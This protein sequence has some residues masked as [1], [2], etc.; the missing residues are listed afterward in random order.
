MSQDYYCH[1][2]HKSLE[3][4]KCDGQMQD[5]VATAQERIAELEAEN[6]KLHNRIGSLTLDN[7]LLRRSAADDVLTIHT[8][9]EIIDRIKKE[10]GDFRAKNSDLE[11]EN[12]KLRAE[13]DMNEYKIRNMALIISGSRDQ[14]SKLLALVERAADHIG[15]SCMMCDEVRREC[16][17]ALK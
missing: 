5:D 16:K 15:C 14:N 6:A 7:D 13:C 4:C 2:C 3:C 17:E 10:N 8:C 12:A 9:Q 11:K 1:Y